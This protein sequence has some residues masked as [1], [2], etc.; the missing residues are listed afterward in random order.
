ML[1][2]DAEPE[3]TRLRV[4]VADTA[5][6]SIALMAIPNVPDCVGVPLSNP[7]TESESPAGSPE[8]EKE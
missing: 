7:A 8:A 1:R 4:A 5:A 2:V 6:E 3:T